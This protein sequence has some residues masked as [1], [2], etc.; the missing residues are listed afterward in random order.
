MLTILWALTSSN[1][2]CNRNMR[3]YKWWYIIKAIKNFLWFKFQVSNSW[4]IACDFLETPSASFML[5]THT[6]LSHAIII[7]LWNPFK[8]P[9]KTTKGFPSLILTT[10]KYFFIIFRH[11]TCNSEIFFHSMDFLK[12]HYFGKVFRNSLIVQLLNNL[13]CWKKYR[14]KPNMF[15]GIT[16][17]W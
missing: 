3:N 6:I 9:H 8:K 7:K 4:L 11:L 17:K 15:Y 14:K 2:S 10:T 16:L 1:A 13:I 12:L 5:S